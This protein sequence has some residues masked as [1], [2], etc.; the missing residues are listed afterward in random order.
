LR[1]RIITTFTAESEG[2]TSRDITKR[3]IDELSKDQ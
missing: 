3:L 2:K 1:H